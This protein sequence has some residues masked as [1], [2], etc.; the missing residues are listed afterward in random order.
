MWCEVWRVYAARRMTNL[1][2]SETAAARGAAFIPRFTSFVVDPRHWRALARHRSCHFSCR[3]VLSKVA[4]RSIGVARSRS[5]REAHL[6][7]LG[8]VRRIGLVDFA[9][10][11]D[12]F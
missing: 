5:V 1:D 11:R 9:V 8:H 6:V 12:V 10:D 4:D 7:F 3:S 2:T